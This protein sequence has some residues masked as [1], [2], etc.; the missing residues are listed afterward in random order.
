MAGELVTTQWLSDHLHDGNVRVVDIRGKV[1]PASAP[2][3]HYFAHREEYW[4]SH[5]EDAV[6]V[7]WTK[8]IVDPNSKSQDIA[9][10]EDFVALIGKLGISNDTHVVAYDDADGMFSARLWWALRYYGHEHVSVL[11]GGWKKWLA[12]GRPTT[13]IVPTFAPTTFVV[14]AHPDLRKTADQVAARHPKTVLLDVRSPGEFCG[15]A[16]RAKRAGHIPNAINLPRTDLVTAE[17]T[18]KS[19]T[20]LR[21]KFADVGI[22]IE[23][24]EVITYCNGGVSASYTLLALTVAGISTGAVYDGSWKDWGNDDSRPIA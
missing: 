4:K 21:E 15:E 10:P 8:D 11:D 2:L 20:E 19:V 14:K 6:F 23:T 12:E 7:D 17:G 5:I 3:P 16:S 22:K 9:S 24:P 18:L 13:D 1:L